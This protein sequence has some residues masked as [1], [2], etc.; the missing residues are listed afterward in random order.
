MNRKR[1]EPALPALGPRGQAIVGGLLARVDDLEF[2][3]HDPDGFALWIATRPGNLLCGF[4]YQAAQV[5][6]ENIRCTACGRPAGNPDTDAV[7]VLKIADW[8]GAHFYLCQS[9]A[10]HDLP[11]AGHHPG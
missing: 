6:A 5:L 8:L 4:C 7:V 9:C 11:L 1:R 2:C 3:E 10:D